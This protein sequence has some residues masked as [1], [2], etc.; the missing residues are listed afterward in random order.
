MAQQG[1]YDNNNSGILSR[2]DRREKDTH[3]EYKG[4]ATIN[5]EEFWISAWVK[6]RKDGSGKFFSLS[7]KPK[8]Q[9]PSTQTPTRQPAQ[10]PA[11]A[12]APP[13]DQFANT[14][15]SDDLPF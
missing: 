6:E 11:P 8:E 2:N 14:D 15:N 9:Q 10:R 12:A 1:Q 7:F 4:S 13:M 5:G 3:P